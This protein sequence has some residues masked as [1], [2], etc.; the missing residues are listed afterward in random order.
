MKKI[1]IS[2]CDGI[3]TD[4]TS[5]YT[6]DGKIAKIYGS[7]DTEAI[8]SAVDNEI[9]FLFVSNDNNGWPITKK[10]LDEYKN[11]GWCEYTLATGK[12]RKELVKKYKDE[13]YFV[14]FVGDSISDIPAG[15]EANL[16]CTTNNG[17]SEVKSEC[18]YVSKRNGG[19]GGFAQII[20]TVINYINYRAHEFV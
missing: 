7:Y 20:Y 13:G 18:Y 10:R 8:K 1:I 9:D 2:D 11:R 19:N 3:L 16:F 14:I 6:Q 17:F 15:K 5:I 12:E 4:G